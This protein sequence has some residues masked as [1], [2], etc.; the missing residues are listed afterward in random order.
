MNSNNVY[1]KLISKML[2]AEILYSVSIREPI[3]V[4]YLLESSKYKVLK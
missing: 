4:L 1:A 2:V 3:K